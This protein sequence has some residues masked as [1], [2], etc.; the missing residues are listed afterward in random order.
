MLMRRKRRAPPFVLG[1]PLNTY[2]RITTDATNN[3][4]SV[5]FADV[6]VS[7]RISAQIFR[8]AVKPQGS[9]AF[10]R[11]SKNVAPPL[12]IPPAGRYRSRVLGRPGHS[13][14]PLRLEGIVSSPPP[15]CLSSAQRLRAAA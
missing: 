5:E 9:I 1:P 11:A 13:Q 4:S 2:G 3:G 10:N 8:S 6:P 15:Q 7:S 12:H 14:R